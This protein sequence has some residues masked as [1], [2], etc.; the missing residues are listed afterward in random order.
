MDIPNFDDIIDSAYSYEKKGAKKF[1]KNEETESEDIDLFK[2]HVS[3]IDYYK[4]LSL[5]QRVEKV[6]KTASLNMFS[7]TKQTRKL[8]PVFSAR[9]DASSVPNI[10]SPVA[11][12]K[13]EQL[14]KIVKTEDLD[15]TVD[16]MQQLREAKMKRK[17]SVSLKETKLGKTDE[18]EIDEK[19]VVP[20]VKPKTVPEKKEVSKPPK[21]PLIQTSELKNSQKKKEE[22]MMEDLKSLNKSELLKRI[23]TLSDHVLMDYSRQNDPKKYTEFT[24]GLINADSFRTSTKVAIAK[25]MG[26]AENE[27]IEYLIKSPFSGI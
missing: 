17:T 21:V 12:S 24:M 23:E 5:W 10:P 7:E 1:K 4:I 19:I 6:K 3:D 25:K 9:N 22:K 11:S 20:E 2:M 27:A 16:M 26:I 14:K 8:E 18:K 15:G 13:T